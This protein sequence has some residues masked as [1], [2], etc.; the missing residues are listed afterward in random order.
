MRNR[1]D[2]KIREKRESISK[3]CMMSVPPLMTLFQFK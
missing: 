3:K 2:Q 1:N